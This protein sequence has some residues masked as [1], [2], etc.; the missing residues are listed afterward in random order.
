MLLDVFLEGLFEVDLRRVNSEEVRARR[1]PRA[2]GPRPAA[3]AVRPGCARARPA[4]ARAR[5]QTSAHKR[6]PPPPRPDRARDE[7]GP[8]GGQRAHQGAH[9]QGVQPLRAPAGA[10]VSRARPRAAPAARVLQ[11]ELGGWARKLTAAPT[12]AHASTP[13]PPSPRPRPVRSGR[14]RSTA[15]SARWAR[16]TSASTTPCARGGCRPRTRRGRALHARCM[17]RPRAR[18][19]AARA[20][21]RAWGWRMARGARALTPRST[22]RPAD[23]AVGVPRALEGPQDGWG[24]VGGLQTKGAACCCKPCAA[25]LQW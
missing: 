20:P 18:V 7:H 17:R 5:A 6:A 24:G 8:R 12:Q 22:L 13:S 10:A 15:A 16:C 25:T 2:R 21:R 1:L 23:G 11:S 19:R 14:W 3:A 9:A 4:P